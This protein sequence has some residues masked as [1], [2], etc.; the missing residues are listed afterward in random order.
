MKKQGGWGVPSTKGYKR[1][2]DA[3][4]CAGSIYHGSGNTVHGTLM[5]L[6]RNQQVLRKRPFA[7]DPLAIAP[8]SRASRHLWNLF[9]LVL[10]RAFRPDGL[11]FIQ[12]EPQTRGRNAYRLTPRGTQM[13]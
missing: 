1:G 7:V 2:P 3:L 13:H 4:Q 6:S 12:H 11:V 10:V 8:E 9:G 5:L